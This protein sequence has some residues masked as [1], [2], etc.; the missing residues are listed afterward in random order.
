MK[1]TVRLGQVLARGVSRHMKSHGFVSLQE[2][3]PTKGLRVD[4]MAL[5]PRGQFWIIECKSS[6][7]DFQ[8]DCKWTG[9]LEWCDSYY[10]AVDEDFP[11]ELLPANSGLIVSDGFDAEIIRD[12]SLAPLVAAR[13]KALMMRFARAAA[14]RLHRLTDPDAF[15]LP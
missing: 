14:G 2:F 3:S 12:G 9:Y 13:R 11:N 6:R 7:A 4:V 5:G 1:T 10:W 15:R 8:A